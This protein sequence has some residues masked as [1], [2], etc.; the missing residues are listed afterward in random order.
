MKSRLTIQMMSHFLIF[1]YKI[2]ANHGNF[3][4]NVSNFIIS[5]LSADGKAPLDDKAPLAFAG[6]AITMWHLESLATVIT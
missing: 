6:T 3:E 5:T 1:F 2:V 4:W